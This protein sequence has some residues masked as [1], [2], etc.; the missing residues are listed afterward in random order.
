MPESFGARLRRTREEQNIALVTIAQQTK[1]KLS[2]LEGL[3]RDD[4]AHWP[5]GIFRRA[6]I[7][8]Y[9]QAIGLNPDAV[10]RE[11]LEVHPEPEEEFETALAAALAVDAARANGGSR[12]KSMFGSAL[13]TLSRLAGAASHAEKPDRASS[14]TNGRP[15]ESQPLAIL[16]GSD[17]EAFTFGIHP[18]TAM[19]RLEMADDAG[20]Q[21]VSAGGADFPAAMIDPER[22]ESIMR[23]P[24]EG[25]QVRED[26][27]ATATQ[28]DVQGVVTS[29]SH[30]QDSALSV[31]SRKEEVKEDAA[32]ADAGEDRAKS[33]PDPADMLALAHLCTE[34]G[35]VERAED[36]NALLELCAGT[37]HARGLI[38]WVWDEATGRLRPGLAHGYSDRVLA[39]IPALRPDA[40]N[41]TAA[42]F[43]TRQT[44]SV[45]GNER[46]SGALVLPLLVPSG[47][48]GVLALELEP[49]V[50]ASEWL[51]AV[52]TILA[53][54]LAQLVDRARGAAMDAVADPGEVEKPMVRAGAR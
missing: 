14:S 22:F 16:P 32:P 3:E 9:A 40:D 38:V 50:E 7:R 23:S 19:P 17:E 45:A 26:E 44:C 53:A 36:L 48:V 5:S 46:T 8:A 54:M 12:L 30:A 42:A 21:S 1:I 39:Q 34:L 4:V 13:G 25:E 35:R 33:A 20:L 15:V 18:P 29:A 43:R 49:K 37:L 31:Q 51:Q 28:P 41:A 10:V 2:L 52:A 6:Y 11:F 24:D 27:E 47:C